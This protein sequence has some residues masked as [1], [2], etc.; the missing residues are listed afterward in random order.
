MTANGQ[1]L[2]DGGHLEALTCRQAQM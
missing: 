1:G 2:G